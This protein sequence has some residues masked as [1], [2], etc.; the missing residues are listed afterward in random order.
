MDM[1]KLVLRIP[2]KGTTINMQEMNICTLAYKRIH[3]YSRLNCWAVTEATML[4]LVISPQPKIANVCVKTKLAS[5][6]L[7]SGSNFIRDE[8]FFSL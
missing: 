3:I 8:R 6:N 7:M 5:N 2:S 4:I 1:D